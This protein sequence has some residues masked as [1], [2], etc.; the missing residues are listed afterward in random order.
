[1][2]RADLESLCIFLTAVA[3]LALTKIG[4]K[5]KNKQNSREF[6][7]SNLKL[8]QKAFYSGCPHISVIDIDH[9]LLVIVRSITRFRKC[10]VS[11]FYQITEE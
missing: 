6:F 7:F 11:H 2:S 9:S 1:M 5:E 3:K 10:L 4:L 8:F